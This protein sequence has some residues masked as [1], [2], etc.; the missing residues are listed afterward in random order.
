LS[1]AIAGYFKLKIYIVSLNSMAMNEENLGT[2]FAELPKQ[3]VPPSHP[4]KPH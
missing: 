1:F 3:Y 4:Q 2:L